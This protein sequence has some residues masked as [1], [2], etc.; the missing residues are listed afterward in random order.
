MIAFLR[1][2]GKTPN[3]ILDGLKDAVKQL[4]ELGLLWEREDEEI[5]LG[6]SSGLNPTNKFEWYYDVTDDK[7]VLTIHPDGSSMTYADY[8]IGIKVLFNLEFPDTE[9]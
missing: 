9:E 7:G 5:F 1:V 4:P 8:L 2:K 6:F 3:D